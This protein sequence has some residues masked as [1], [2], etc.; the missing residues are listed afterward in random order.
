MNRTPKRPQAVKNLR[1]SP[2]PNA[3]FET[4]GFILSFTSTR[5]GCA[6][7]ASLLAIACTA[8]AFA[9]EAPADTSTNLA[10]ESIVVT[11]QRT[12]YNNSTTTP[13]MVEDIAPVSSVLDVIDTLPGVQ[14]QQ[15][16]AFGF[17][18]WSTT[19]SVRGFQTNL[20]QQQVGMTIDGLPNGGS[21]YGGG[22]KANRYIDTMNIG[23]VSVSQGT[24]DIASRSNEALG[25]TIDYQT[26]DPLDARRVRFSGSV[27]DYQARR[28]YGRFD[29]GLIFNDTTKA[30]FS[31]SHQ[32]AT[33]WMEG[34]ANNHRDNAEAKF[35]VD[36]PVKFTGYVSWDKAHEN[37][38]DQ[39]YSA[40]QFAAYPD[41]DGLVGV[42]SGIP[43]Q[44]QA[45]RQVWGTL[46]ENFFAYL[47]ADTTI[48]RN[49]DL[50]GSV[51]YH[52][53][54]GRGDWAPPYVVDVTDDGTGNAESE[55]SGT[56]TV[57]GGSAL[58]YI[59]YTDANKVALTANSSC[60][61]TLTY[62]Y[63][64][65]TDGSYDPSCYA[66][67]AVGAMSYRHT[68]YRKDRLGF[69]GDATWRVQ[70]GTLEN[71][72]RAG[73]WYEDTHRRE[74]RDWHAV[75][76]TAS[77]YEYYSTPYWIQYDRKYPQSTFKWYAEDKVEL[78][79]VTANFG[80]KQFKNDLDRI[81]MF[82][83][84]DDVSL[85]STSKVL[86]SGGLQVTPLA[87]LDLFGG[88]AENYKALT[89]SL[90]EY[91]D[92]DFG[93]IKPE[94]SQNWEAGLRYANG[95]FQGSATWFKA[96]FSNQVIYVSNSTDAGPNYLT[97]GDGTFYNAG[98]I[99]S[100]GFELLA[101][102]RPSPAL[103]LYASYTYTDATYRGTG[104]STL[105][106]DEGVTPGN[107]VAGIPR[108]MWVLSGNYRLGPIS[109]GLTG[110]YTGDRYVNADNSWLAKHYFL[111][112]L[113][114]SARGEDLNAG[115]KGLEFSLAITNL[116]DE[117]YL[118]G[119]SG[120]YAWIG[121]G[122]TMVFTATADF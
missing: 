78:G 69:T 107:R 65:T 105:D 102:L 101:N 1:N 17:D 55:L 93:K 50:S 57:K 12:T 117:S 119:I 60:T 103:N 83:E 114:V 118:G 66:S 72:L 19:I 76:D 112:D 39:V 46:R 70:L 47:K 115:L 13:E 64:G 45:Y 32:Q 43:Y 99:D 68:H 120:D 2:A 27:G 34:S 54:A 33:D 92:S 5:R 48:G 59:Y 111:T 18:D 97:E 20:D 94:T 98:G 14:V 58:G 40:A 82:G 30:W 80:I 38:Y 9:E 28:Y 35:I 121:A 104:N 113:N 96:K 23:A 37:N 75:I 84:T 95:I 77:G 6:L 86:F 100:Q 89:D 10:A 74:W 36:T 41:T 81:D 22:S 122:R 116:T 110:K 24:S 63:G 61:G 109:L 4:G 87:G 91:T 49:L 15:G 73:L 26:S 106:E 11:G 44:D 29:T 85:S 3:K 56:T 8:P 52:D 25:G 7:G 42:W 67:G 71:S 51:Y 79:P 16:D 31:Y 90:L 108:N 62:P 53:M 21:N 88:Y